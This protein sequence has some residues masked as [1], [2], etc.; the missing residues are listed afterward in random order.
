[1]DQPKDK[2]ESQSE[3]VLHFS[4]K[5]QLA[6]EILNDNDT[7][8]LV[9]GGAGGGGKTA[10]VSL[11]MV[12]ECVNNPGIKIALGREELLRLKQTTLATIIGF[13]H[14]VLGV[15]QH[16]FTY[17]GSS[18]TLTYQNGSLIQLLHMAYSPQDPNY[19]TLGSLDY[20]HVVIEEAGE[21][22][23]KAKAVLGSRR[24]RW[25]NE[26]Y[27]ITG[28]LIMTC[29]PSK[30]FL[31]DRYYTPY[32][33]LGGGDIQRWEQG[34]IFFD[35]DWHP[36]YHAFI[37]SLVTDNPFISKNYIETLR[38]LPSSERKRLLEGDWE[39]D[40]NTDGMFDDTVM[41]NGLL[42][43]VIPD[44][45]ESPSIFIGVDVADTGADSTIATVSQNDIAIRHVRFTIDTT[46]PISISDQQAE[47]L[48][49]LATQYG[50]SSHHAQHIAIEINGVGVGIRD[51][52]IRAGW[53]CAQYQAN[54][55]SRSQGF[56]DL[57]TDMRDGTFKVAIAA[58]SFRSELLRQLNLYD[59]VMDTKLQPKVT[60]K[61]KI[62]DIIGHSP[63]E[64][65]SLMIVNWVR[66]GSNI[67][68][69]AGQ[70]KP[71]YNYSRLGD[72]A[73]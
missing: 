46:S 59:V 41:R 71:D 9:Y 68:D 51:A 50:L 56:Y 17:N 57:M 27:G 19:D 20:T 44:P 6:W 24:N 14:K 32:K 29:N 8:E 16:E 45:G 2:D 36:G 11:W 47:Q 66:R 55:T 69:R 48:I 70:Y 61:E 13:A 38:D 49:A 72:L 22:R 25:K 73:K 26:E 39:F 40:K 43:G 1:M 64:S 65:D 67:Q 28:K 15:E 3:I 63:D 54:G 60:P 52:M 53:N 35:G 10:L 4:K 30:N 33:D 23:E 37:K 18:N 7:T 34:R 62:K 5:Q 58:L 12:I 31:Y 21:V 42:H